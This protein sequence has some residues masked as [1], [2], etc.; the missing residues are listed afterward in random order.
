MTDVEYQSKM[1]K[2]DSSLRATATQ[3]GLKCTDTK[4]LWS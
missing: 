1:Y 4:E 2:A 3:P